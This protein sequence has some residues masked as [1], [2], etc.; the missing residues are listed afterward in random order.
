MS[1]LLFWDKDNRGG[2]PK[3]APIELKWWGLSIMI[4]R[5]SWI[6]IYNRFLIGM[7]RRKS[8]ESRL[9]LP[10]R[11]VIQRWKVLWLK[12]IM[13]KVIMQ[14][15][16]ITMRDQLKLK[17]RSLMSLITPVTSILRNLVTAVVK[18]TLDKGAKPTSWG[19]WCSHRLSRRWNRM[20]SVSKNKWLRVNTKV[21]G[22]WLIN[23]RILFSPESRKTLS[24]PLWRRSKRSS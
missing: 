21:K 23:Q 11:R 1:Q 10:L 9:T 17:C 2:S 3:G 19:T 24:L 15:S 7:I 18:S 20:N 13:I 8:G 16:W 4:M 14:L 5:S 12:L 22:T 6:R